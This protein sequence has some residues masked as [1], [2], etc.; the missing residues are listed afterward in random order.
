MAYDNIIRGIVT[1]KGKEYNFT[2]NCIEES[3]KPTSNVI[4]DKLFGK[5]SYRL[6]N[7]SLNQITL[8]PKRI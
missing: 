4:M 2:A 5:P 3:Y 7:I 8:S 1:Y 6:S